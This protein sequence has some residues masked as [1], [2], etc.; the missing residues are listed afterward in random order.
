MPGKLGFIV[1]S[2][3]DFKE[4]DLLQRYNHTWGFLVCLF[5]LRQ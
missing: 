5:G 1:I 2:N 3:Q 4:E